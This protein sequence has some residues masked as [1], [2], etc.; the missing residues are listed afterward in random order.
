[1][2][3]KGVAPP[4]YEL[5]RRSGVT[6]VAPNVR[7]SSGYGKTY[8]ALDDRERRENA[9]RDIGALLDWIGTQA[10]LDPGR[11]AVSGGSYGG[12]MTL[13]SLVHYSDRVRCGFE[14]FGISD[15]VTYLQG[16]EDSH[17]PQAQRAEFGD[18][19]DPPTRAWLESISPARRAER[20]R[21]PL[22]IF[23]GANDVRVKPR[24]SRQMVERIRAAGGTVT[25]VEAADEGHG[26]EQPLNQLYVG[27]LASEFME[28]CLG[29]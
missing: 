2:Q 7:G 22:L 14:L 15:F 10:D 18:E 8:A 23:Q 20:I 1:M 26:L 17:F 13:A 9:V 29:R 6:I 21:V 24:E 28:R 11:V 16:S 3:T 19:R 5:I 12:Y 27:S 4:H 25:Y